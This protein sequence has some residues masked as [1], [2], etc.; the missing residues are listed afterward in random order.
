M[1]TLTNN[2]ITEPFYDS[3]YEEVGIVSL[4]NEGHIKADQEMRNKNLIRQGKQDVNSY[5]YRG[6]VSSMMDAVSEHMREQNIDFVCNAKITI[7]I[8][9]KTTK[10]TNLDVPGNGR[11]VSSSL[12]GDIK[13]RLTK[14]KSQESNESKV[15]GGDFSTKNLKLVKIIVFFT[16]TAMRKITPTV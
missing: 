2:I 14:K 12:I 15:T 1:T 10:A 6:A 9:K 16:G 3:G 11:E 7:T 13:A 5:I 4:F 8:P